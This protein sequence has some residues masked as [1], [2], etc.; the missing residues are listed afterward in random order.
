MAWCGSRQRRRIRRRIVERDGTSCVYC[1]ADLTGPTITI[2]HLT[3][4]ARGGSSGLANLVLACE[5]CNVA[6]GSA[7]PLNFVILRRNAACS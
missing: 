5:G 7:L 6:K 1:G 3:P 4:L 2:D